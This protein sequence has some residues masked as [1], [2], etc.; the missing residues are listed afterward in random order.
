MKHACQIKR[1]DPRNPGLYAVAKPSKEEKAAKDK[2]LTLKQQGRLEVLKA[3][4]FARNIHSDD[5]DE[6]STAAN[7]G[8]ETKKVV[9]VATNNWQQIIKESKK[10]KEEV[11]KI[12]FTADAVSK[13]ADVSAPIVA[14]QAE[15]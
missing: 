12:N 1:F 15:K 2:P 8:K 13:T 11:K 5:E 3:V 14:V 6:Q 10:F 7:R 4:S 9:K